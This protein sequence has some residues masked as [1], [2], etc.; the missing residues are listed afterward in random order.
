[1]SKF[2]KCAPVPPGA[3]P[4]PYEEYCYFLKGQLHPDK[5]FSERRARY[6]YATKYVKLGFG[7]ITGAVSSTGD[8]VYYDH[9]LK[10]ID[11]EQYRLLL[12]DYYEGLS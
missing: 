2:S 3:Q 9:A 7:L 6:H 11:Y 1:M 10:V 8:N 5:A 4:V 12:N